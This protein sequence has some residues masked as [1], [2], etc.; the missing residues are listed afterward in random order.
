MGEF[1]ELFF[2]DATVA[3]D[4]LGI[5]LTRRG[6]HRGKPIPMCG[7]PV[8]AVDNCLQTL[9]GKGFRV[10]V[11]EQLERPSA[12]KSRNDSVVKRGVTRVISPGTVSE[13]SL[14]DAC[15]HNYL[16]AFSE[17]RGDG[18]MAWTDITTGD[19]LVQR[20][21]MVFIGPLL[22]ELSP[23]EVLLSE[24]E[25]ETVRDLFSAF[26]VLITDRPR[27][28]FESIS[29]N[30]RL[31]NHFRVGSLD[32]YGSFSV[33][34]ISA[35]GAIVDYLELSQSGRRPHL[36]PPT[37]KR[38]SQTLQIDAATRRNLELTTNLA[39]KRTHS[40][41]RT[42]DRTVTGAGARLLDRRLSSPST[43]LPVIER[44]LDSVEF[45]VLQPELGDTC[46]KILRSVPEMGRALGRLAL[47]HGG[48]GDLG[49]IRDGLEKSEILF[50]AFTD[51]LNQAD[52]G[53][54]SEELTAAVASL[55]GC[56]D[57]Q[58]ELRNALIAIPPATTRDGGFIAPG[59]HSELDRVRT[60]RDDGRKLIADLQARYC[61][62][63]GIIS[64]KIR[65]NN[66]L[67][68]FVE[69]RA[70]H[71]KTMLD[72]EMGKTFIHRQ[73]LANS[74]RFST[75][76]L[77]QLEAEIN[78][79][80]E[81]A[82]EIEL[83]IFDRLT[84]MVLESTNPITGA[85]AAIAVVDVSAALADLARGATWTR[86]VVCPDHRFRVTGGRH[87]V[88]EM[89]LKESASGS[90]VANDCD[91][92]GRDQTNPHI[93]LLTGP[94]MAGKSTFLRQNAL[95][96][97]LAQMGSFVPATKAE[98]GIASQLFSRVGA[99]DDLASGRST[100]MVEMVETAAI[101]NSADRNAF[102]I[103][104]EIGR[105]TATHDGL[106]IA[107]A[108]LEYLHEVNQCRTLFATHYHEL[109]KLSSRLARLFNAT[110]T[111]KE[112][113]GEI[114]FLHQV[115]PGAADKSYG[116]QVAQ[117]AGLPP[118]VI[119]RARNVLE[120][121]ETGDHDSGSIQ[122]DKLL[123]GLPLFEQ[124]SR[125]PRQPRAEP[126]PALAR[127]KE[128]HPDDLSPREA[129]DLVYELKSLAGTNMTAG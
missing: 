113:N 91:L 40:L 107:W 12:A 101:L 116:V 31:L 26:D 79:A 44:N 126:S 25:D 104:D 103:L 78:A 110:V 69:T 85:T 122:P 29:A 119:E 48:P 81:R 47:G 109:T 86:P 97:V 64:L 106:S 16:C 1:Y 102:V 89:A 9:I 72:E 93:W 127:L 49:A 63:T 59:F 65:H 60:V 76:E 115:R 14:L 95:I 20:C 23:K 124:V 28:S 19:F 30:D 80:T 18:A 2:D 100:F 34:Q 62:I 129:L 98:I 108:T 43:E 41:L 17:I 21:P 87:P 128:A 71:G 67:G 36:L 3:A 52:S 66:I 88:V 51:F 123:E 121:L 96:L 33:P 58:T 117:L 11:C 55:H 5:T 32:G 83:T 24:A 54:L 118:A 39:G 74:I 73:T 56:E 6:S 35:M 112:W 68:Y 92:S 7:M 111:V 77:S 42:I 27:S 125:I 57:L 4:A 90:F 22:A 13:D 38:S 61:Q 15:H 70:R 82:L 8:H 114:H 99:A 46:R 105:G 120:M 84:D 75:V 10:A 37:V 45:F 53:P 94:N 50:E